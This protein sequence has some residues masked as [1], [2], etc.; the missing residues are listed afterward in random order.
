MFT[1]IV[2]YPI[3]DAILIVPAI[4]ILVNFRKE[5]LWF[6]PWICES[7]GIFLMALSDSWFAPVILTSL[8]NQLWLSSLFFSGAHYLVIAAG[9]LWYA[10]FLTSHSHDANESGIKVSEPSKIIFNGASSSSNDNNYTFHKKENKRTSS[11]RV[12]A[13]ISLLTI[14]AIVVGI[15][16]YSS[17]SNHYHLYFLG[18]PMQILR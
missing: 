18:S 11:S 6:T 5:P 10:K 4:V 17:Y 7:A 14:V 1:V 15:I 2:A 3:L 9:L 8:V 13:A 12:F 16:L